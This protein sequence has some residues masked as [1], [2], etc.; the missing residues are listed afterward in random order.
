MCACVYVYNV[1][2]RIHFISEI[3]M[4]TLARLNMPA[5]QHYTFPIINFQHVAGPRTC[6]RVLLFV[7]ALESSC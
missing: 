7:R 5:V 3:I 6:L 1:C 4:R 2:T